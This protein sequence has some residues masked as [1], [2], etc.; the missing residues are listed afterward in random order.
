MMD[1]G[2]LAKR[3]RL[4]GIGFGFNGMALVFAFGPG[5]L[6]GGGAEAAV[7][8]PGEDFPLAV[9]LFDHHVEDVGGADGPACLVSSGP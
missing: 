5:L 4:S 3:S 7:A 6:P 8:G 1:Q 2:R 9:L